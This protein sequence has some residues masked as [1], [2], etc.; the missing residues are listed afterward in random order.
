[1][2]AQTSS[3]D[4]LITVL[5]YDLATGAPRIVRCADCGRLPPG[6]GV[7]RWQAD[8]AIEEDGRPLQARLLVVAGIDVADRPPS[9]PLGRQQ[10]HAHERRV[11]ILCGGR[12]DGLRAPLEPGVAGG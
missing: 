6:A 9:L 8:R 3:A 2:R 10:Q 5:A 1:M 4:A 7:R 11:L 12:V